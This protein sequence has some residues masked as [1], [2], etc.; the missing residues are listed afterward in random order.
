MMA[1]EFSKCL[2]NYAAMLL[3][4]TKPYLDERMSFRVQMKDPLS[5]CIACD[6]NR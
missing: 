4:G 3:F 6:E 2:R 1:E 5:F